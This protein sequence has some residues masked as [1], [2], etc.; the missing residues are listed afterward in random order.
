M[1]VLE[2]GI[3]PDLPEEL[4]RRGQDRFRVDEERMVVSRELDVNALLGSCERCSA[5]LRREAHRLCDG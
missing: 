2:G 3:I 1:R 4:A 5:L